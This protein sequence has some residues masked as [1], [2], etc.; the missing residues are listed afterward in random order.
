M[1][2]STTVP[3]KDV[4]MHALDLNMLKLRGGKM[5][6]LD[7]ILTSLSKEGWYLQGS[8]D[9]KYCLNNYPNDTTIVEV[10]DKPIGF[11]VTVPMT[12]TI[13]FVTF[14]VV[15]ENYRGQRIGRLLWKSMVEKAKGRQLYL[16]ANTEHKD[17]YIRRGLVNVEYYLDVIVD[18]QFKK[19]TVDL[20]ICQV[21]M[22]T[23]D[24]DMNRLVNYDREITSFDRSNYL[25]IWLKHTDVKTYV[26][27][28]HGRIAGYASVSRYDCRTRIGPVFADSFNIARNL[29]ATISSA[30]PDE[31]MTLSWLTTQRENIT[32]LF[33]DQQEACA[34]SDYEI[35]YMTNGSVLPCNNDKIFVLSKGD[36]TRC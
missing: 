11:I 33:K 26:A 21:D 17:M 32:S 36:M 25:Y 30:L 27:Y 13:L 35:S 14:L 2:L 4:E 20:E 34:K 23:D 10:N 3:Q 8:E 16:V 18:V 15:S 24:D 5:E 28:L 6:D 29:I 9:I 31:P 1:S 19:V 7:F 12:D 22:L